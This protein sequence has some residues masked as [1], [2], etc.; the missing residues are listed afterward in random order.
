MSFIYVYPPQSVS[1]VTPPIQFNYDG[2]E[3]TVSEDTLNPTNSIPLPVKAID[4]SG[5]PLAPLTDAE[6]RANPIEVDVTSL[7][8]LPA[9]TNNIGDVDVVSLPSLPAGSNNIGDVDILSLPVSFDV[10]AAD[11]TTQRVVIASSQ[12]V[13]IS[14]TSLPL[15]SDAATATKQ[16]ALLAELQLKADLTETQPV[17]VASLP[18][19]SG[20]ATAAKQDTGNT[21]LGNI[22][23]KTP[24]LV[25]GRV[26]VDGSG[27]TQPISA[28]SL[29]LPTGATTEATLSAMSSKLPASIGQKTMANSL[30]VAIASDQGSVKTAQTNSKGEFVRNDYSS[31]NVTTS[32]YTQLISSTSAAYSALEVFDSSG[33]TLKL[34][35]GGAG[36]EVDQFI[37]FPGGNGR[38]P[39]TIASGSRI[40][41]RA[42]SATANSGEIDINFYV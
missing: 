22:D 39:F 30:S 18:L 40:S 3:T 32:A 16:D 21:S 11:A 8:S 28:A 29:P 42:L 35:I 10:G 15:P 23:T 33:Q 9:G 31:V 1:V 20:A 41:I 37:I 36:S 27:V 17:S 2:V 14:A 34:A 38:I 5:N 26:P 12:T 6:L 24:S 25:S 4:A 13:P 7:P 19:P